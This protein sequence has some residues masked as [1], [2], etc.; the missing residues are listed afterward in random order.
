MLLEESAMW[1][2]RFYGSLIPLERGLIVSFLRIA[3]SLVV[4]EPEPRT[5]TRST[6]FTEAVYY[7]HVCGMSCERHTLHVMYL[8]VGSMSF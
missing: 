6:Y 1:C 5:Q 8:V 3:A 7:S 4:V 2:F